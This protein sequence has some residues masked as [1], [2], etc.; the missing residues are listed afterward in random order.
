MNFQKKLDK[1]SEL[2]VNKK[3]NQPNLLLLELDG[4]WNVMMKLMLMVMD[5]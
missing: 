2:M 1:V 5:V 4:E 3:E